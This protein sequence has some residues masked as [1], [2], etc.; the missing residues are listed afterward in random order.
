M[1][2]ILLSIS[3]TISR[4]PEHKFS[5]DVMKS[6]L[7]SL[8]LSKNK[9]FEKQCT[10]FE[11]NFYIILALNFTHINIMLSYR[12][13]SE[14]ANQLMAIKSTEPP[15]PHFDRLQDTKWRIDVTIS[16]RYQLQNM[17]LKMMQLNPRCIYVF[18]QSSEP[19]IGSINSYGAQLTVRDTKN[20]PHSTLSISKS[21]ISSS[22]MF[23][24]V[25]QKF[26]LIF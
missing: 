25:Q 22:H 15:M 20:N 5:V 8:G 11:R 7:L 9:A 4:T 6:E 2:A 3:L 1:F 16:T 13:T 26:N 24:A 17:S 10:Q 18:F 12:F 19:C 21:Q 23:E 14:Q